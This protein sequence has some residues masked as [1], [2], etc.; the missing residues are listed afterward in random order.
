MTHIFRPA[1]FKNHQ[2]LFIMK[3]YLWEYLQVLMFARQ[4]I[5]ASKYFA[6]FS[7]AKRTWGRWQHN[8]V[9]WELSHKRCEAMNERDGGKREEGGLE[10]K[11]NIRSDRR[12]AISSRPSPWALQVSQTALSLLYFLSAQ[13]A[14]RNLGRN[15]V[16]L[17][18]TM[19]FIKAI[20]SR[21]V[22]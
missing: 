4:N 22:H 1:L 2:T 15:H 3:M 21:S 10:E 5:I 6:L 7:C 18:H 9:A 12:N 14:Q 13:K 17:V 16:S 8:R 20:S 19:S 11:K